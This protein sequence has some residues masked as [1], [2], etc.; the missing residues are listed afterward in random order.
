L[1]SRKTTNAMTAKT[2][3]TATAATKVLVSIT[4]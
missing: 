4:S 1:R 2:R 3:P